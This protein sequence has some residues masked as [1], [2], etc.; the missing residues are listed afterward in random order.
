ML[1]NSITGETTSKVK[2]IR[3]S[4][5][6][7]AAVVSVNHYTVELKRIKKYK[8]WVENSCS[9]KVFLRLPLEEKVKY[10]NTM[11]NFYDECLK[12]R[13]PPSDERSESSPVAQPHM[14]GGCPDFNDKSKWENVNDSQG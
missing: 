1:H 7:T 10:Q 9:Y 6:E 14:E 3:D 12:N 5:E 8:E 13:Q 4:A 2:R 11:V